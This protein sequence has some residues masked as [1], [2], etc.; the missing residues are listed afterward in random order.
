MNKKLFITFAMFLLL[1]SFVFAEEYNLSNDIA[2]NVYLAENDLNLNNSIYGDAF[3]VSNNV[4]I[5]GL[6]DKDLSVISSDFMLTGTVGDDLRVLSSSINIEGYV[7]NEV[8]LYGSYVSISNSSILGGPVKIYANA[9]TIDGVIKGDAKVYADRIVFNGIIE[10]DAYFESDDLIMGPDAQVL[11]NFISSKDLEINSSNV[12]GQVIDSDVKENDGFIGKL[13]SFLMLVVVG[14]VVLLVARKFAVRTTDA[15][16]KRSFASFLAGLIIL[17]ATPIVAV[18]LLITIIGVPLAILLFIAYG[19]VIFLGAI[20][21]VFA[22]GKGI[23]M[24]IDHK[25]KSLLLS[26][27]LGA[28]LFTLISFVPAIFTLVVIIAIV[29]G[30][31]G[32]WIALRNKPKK[33]K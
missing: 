20:Y 15:I 1:S 3:F 22:I 21:G 17:I 28:L 12:H 11:G 32:F 24:I 9:V 2:S 4:A 8:L 31:G 13:I 27:I 29:F 5:N 7:F 6:V 25:K 14:F 33:K 10:K 30:I 16:Q 23:L 18:L 19:L 26:M